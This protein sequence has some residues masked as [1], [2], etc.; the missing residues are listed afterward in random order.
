MCPLSSTFP[1][2]ICAGITDKD[3]LFLCFGNDTNILWSP[4]CRWWNF[5]F[6]NAAMLFGLSI[7]QIWSSCVVS[8]LNIE[9][10]HLYHTSKQVN[11]PKR[12]PAST[13]HHFLL[14]ITGLFLYLVEHWPLTDFYR[15]AVSG[16]VK[17]VDFI[18]KYFL[19]GCLKVHIYGSMFQYIIFLYYQIIFYCIAKPVCFFIYQLM[20]I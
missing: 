19:L 18:A 11:T 2:E 7:H 4:V 17:C 14:T 13:S 10:H 20:N 15:H 8:Y 1:I 3:L 6:Y 5:L 12:K 9:V 16:H